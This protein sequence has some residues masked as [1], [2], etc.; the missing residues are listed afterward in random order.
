MFDKINVWK[1]P[2]IFGP[3]LSEQ[4]FTVI[5]RLAWA[6]VTGLVVAM[7]GYFGLWKR[8]KALEE[9]LKGATQ[10]IPIKAK[11]NREFH[12]GWMTDPRNNERKQVWI[13]QVWLEFE[14]GSVKPLDIEGL[15]KDNEILMFPWPV[16]FQEKE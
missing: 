7:I 2:P 13:P 10:K 14:D 5:S 8:V 9:E 12:I 4:R 15:V 16:R 1:L 3:L 6:I 11:V